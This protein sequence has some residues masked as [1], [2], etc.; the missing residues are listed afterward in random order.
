MNE[1]S[2]PGIAFWA[3]VVIVVV[4]VAYPLSFGPACWWFSKPEFKPD[5]SKG[6]VYTSTLLRDMM[7]PRM[8][9]PIG[10]TF[11]YGPR[12]VRPL[13]RWYALIGA[14]GDRLLLPVDSNGTTIWLA[15]TEERL[16]RAM[17][18]SK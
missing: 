14:P 17:R 8:Y 7:P 15:S 4:L 10:R 9:W 2:K 11:A 13:I 6:S 12:P 18:F 1:G 16:K 3:T 5:F